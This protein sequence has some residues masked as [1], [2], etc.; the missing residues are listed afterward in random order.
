[1]AKHH[2]IIIILTVLVITACS[3]SRHFYRSS[4]PGNFL[5]SPA[6]SDAHAGI[7][8]Y[9]PERREYLY[10]HNADKFFLPAS[11]VKL[12]TLYA[13]LKYLEGAV[14]GIMYMQHDDTIFLRATGDPTFMVS[15]FASQPVLGFL[16]NAGMPMVF[17]EPAW[18]TGALGFGWPWN[19]YLDYYMAERSPFPVHGNGITWTQK[20]GGHEGL[21]P[22]AFVSAPRVPW[23][24]TITGETCGRFDVKRPP[25]IN[26][27][28]ICPGPDGERELFVP[29][30]TG[31]MKASLELLRDTLQREV[32]LMPARPGMTDN[33]HTIYSRPVDSLFIPMMHFSDNFYAEQTLLM[34]SNKLFGVMDEKLVI[35]FLASNDFIAIP[36]SPRWVDGSGLSRYNLVS[37]QSIIWLLEK[38]TG[39][40]GLERI[41]RLLP[42]G[43]Q[44]TLEGLYLD[45]KGK[46]FAK[47]G[48]LG[49]NAVALSG[50]L[51]T[52]NGRTLLFSVLVNNQNKDS[53]EVRLAIQ[54]FIREII[55][56]Y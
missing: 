9:D 15:E 12:A 8:I 36:Q 28:V 45:E 32:R 4:L 37:P 7:A 48:T 5:D 30:F 53:K 19:F 38:L 34:V 35:D 31:G 1:M 27:Y 10:T 3:P 52:E 49:G 33:Y 22:V 6:V 25:S 20:P 39:E 26:D 29:F 55:T 11:N 14:P 43:G 56:R 54:D 42:T 2:Q 50:V 23:R 47:T 41:C 51:L 40:F 46:I 44:G 24:V 21:P 17:L 16:Q 13:G 18:E